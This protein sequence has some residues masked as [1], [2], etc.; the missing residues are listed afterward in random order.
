MTS[1]VVAGW[2]E[3]EKRSNEDPQRGG[4]FSPLLGQFAAVGE[5]QYLA[6]V[7]RCGRLGCA[8]RLATSAQGQTK[9]LLH[10]G[11]IFDRG[12]NAFRMSTRAEKQWKAARQQGQ[13]WDRFSPKGRHPRPGLLFN[14]LWSE[15]MIQIEV[16]FPVSVKCPL[17]GFANVIEPP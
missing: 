13:P 15:R 9:G 6:M 17:C 7:A 11:L 2:R 1:Q 5:R 10:S 3:D 14:D 12:T 8:A 4:G 16:E